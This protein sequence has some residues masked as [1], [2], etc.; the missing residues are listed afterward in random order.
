MEVKLCHKELQIKFLSS[1][2]AG[3]DKQLLLKKA[4]QRQVHLSINFIPLQ[5]IHTKSIFLFESVV[6][7]SMG[8]QQPCPFIHN[9]KSPCSTWEEGWIFYWR[10]F[11]FLLKT[12]T[13]SK[14]SKYSYVWAFLQRSICKVARAEQQR[15]VI[16]SFPSPSSLYSLL[17]HI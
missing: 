1:A 16:K 3:L 12:L 14:K 5:R 10:I 13:F 11:S 7:L 2:W 4:E 9:W 17:V 15:S 6:E 8:I